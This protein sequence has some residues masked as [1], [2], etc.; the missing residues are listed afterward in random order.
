MAGLVGAAEL[1]LKGWRPEGRRLVAISNS[2][3]SC[4]MAADLAEELGLPLASFAEA[5]RRDL[6]AVLPGFATTANPIDITA[7]L[8]SNSRLFGAILPI[9]AK[10]PAADLFLIAIPVAG[11]GYDV[12]AFARDA[13]DFAAVTGKPVAVAAPQAI[14]AERFRAAGVPTFAGE[15][16]AVM[17]LDQLARHWELLRRPPAP[18][19]PSLKLEVPPGTGRFLNEAESLA[20]VAAHGLPVVDHR[21]C[22][23]ESEVRIAFRELGSPVA[24]KACSAEVPHKSE[25]GL[26]ALDL[27]S[28]EAV[29]QAFAAQ[30]A[31]LA[32][33]GVTADGIIIAAM[34][35]GRHEFML[36]A[37]LDPVF[38]PVVMIGDGGKYVEALPDVALLLPPFS[39]ADAVAAVKSLH[40]APILAGV[41][42]EPALDIDAL[43]HAALKLG[44]IICS[45]QGRI[46]AIDI[47]PALVDAEGQ[48]VTIVD[49]LVERVVE[50]R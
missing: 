30:L 37:K 3:A 11:Q 16:E 47:N 43:A 44:A 42:G 8:L 48:G 13:A 46:A 9:V 20:L 7:A 28:E 24:V 41:R 18:P 38:G 14:V 22:R 17:A 10:D 27:V 35:A 1:Y 4:V 50:T 33:M 40:I 45:A 2:G 25:H 26:V 49:A 19:L 32:A 39:H 21:L 29:V 34:A 5:T 6:A 31:K 36:G 15:T 12:D 23:S